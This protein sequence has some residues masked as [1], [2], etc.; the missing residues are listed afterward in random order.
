MLRL[1]VLA[2]LVVVAA[3]ACG[4]PPLECATVDLACT[5]QYPPTFANVFA[6]T[7]EPDCSAAAC[8]DASNPKGNLDLSEIDVAY[9]GLLDG[10]VDPADV[11]CSE[12]VARLYTDEPAWHMPRGKTLTD[13]EQCAVAQWVAA[14]ALR[15][16]PAT[17]A[18][19][20]AGT[21]SP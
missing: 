6:Q 4:D 5:P 2:A 16:E 8:H 3:G 14:G 13:S 7:L 17:A 21:P 10:H 18:A 9:D 11:A 15:D 12:L 20:P 19:P 1:A